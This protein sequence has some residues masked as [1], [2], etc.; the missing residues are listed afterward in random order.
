MT[1]AVE[2]GVQERPSPKSVRDQ[3]L[4]GFW[5]ELRVSCLENISLL[6]EIALTMMSGKIDE[7][8]R[9]SAQAG[10]KMLAGAFSTL[11][12]PEG[13]LL[14][15]AV[16]RSLE[17]DG[18]LGATECLQ[19]SEG[20]VSMRRLVEHGP[21]N[22]SVPPTEEYRTVVLFVDGDHD[23]A[24]RLALEA[25]EG[26]F[27]IEIA[28]SVAAAREAVLKRVPD[29]LLVDP[30]LPEG[31][32]QGMDFVREFSST[33]ALSPIVMFTADVSFQDRLDAVRAGAQAILQKPLALPQTL[34]LLQR[35][36][37]SSKKLRVRVMAVSDDSALLGCLQQL[38]E[39]NGMD[40]EC[41]ADPLLCGG[42]LE[43]SEPDVLI[44][45]GEMRS[46][47]ALDFCRAAKSDLE[48]TAPPIIVVGTADDETARRILQAGADRYISKAVLQ[49]DLV[50]R[51]RILA[52]AGNGRELLIN[53]S[54]TSEEARRFT[55]MF[56]AASRRHRIRGQA[57]FLAAVDIDRLGQITAT[58]GVRAAAKVHR[59]LG[60][61]L[62]GQ[63][64]SGSVL[65]RWRGDEF[66]VGVRAPTRAEAMQ[67]ITMVLQSLGDEPF[68]GT[69][70]A[71]FHVTASA[72]I[73][74][75]L[76]D[77]TEF[78][79]LHQAADEALCHAVT[80]GGNRIV[81][82]GWRSPSDPARDSLD[83][84]I[85]DGDD[86]V[87]RVLMHAL[88]TRGYRAQ[89]LT[90]GSEALEHLARTLK[91]RVVLLD[92]HLPGLDGMSLLQRLKAAGA[93][94]QTRVI[95]ITARSSEMEIVKTL[96]LGAFDHVSKPFSV[97]VLMQRI[98]R[99]I[100]N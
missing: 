50:A 8:Q 2:S 6:D 21:A 71:E 19:I 78:T 54:F 36:V 99:A 60:Q 83:I 38:L 10:A 27:Q 95:V 23:L 30:C 93:L 98:R 52:R 79:G 53:E 46:C 73:A 65:T 26:M 75:Q 13:V 55:A 11:N 96:E 4:G 84:L 14:A 32:Q 64:G 86:A 82:A 25:D 69:S 9:A 35:V 66:L 45:D 87:G 85:L 28:N 16:E 57:I 80:T 62:I 5:A 72:G 89:W 47:S 76:V 94:A 51:V 97:P 29:I 81:P 100:E 56:D 33:H 17:G 42:A 74:Q 70:G 61:L 43:T 34:D 44:V 63:F 24:C 15:Q 39:S 22:Y 58:H 77:G 37:D 7:G 59:S 90:T 31:R 92:V 88:T 3:M 48:W 18:L 20:A 91:P 12:V 41:L 68:A 49:E 1:P 40:C 67:R